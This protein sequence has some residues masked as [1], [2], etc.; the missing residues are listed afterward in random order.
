LRF[1]YPTLWSHCTPSSITA[2]TTSGPAR[3][4][5]PRQVRARTYDAVQLLRVVRRVDPGRI[6]IVGGL[7]V[8]GAATVD[9]RRQVA[10][11]ALAVGLVQE[12]VAGVVVDVRRDGS[13]E[14]RIATAATGSASAAAASA[15]RRMREGMGGVIGLLAPFAC[16]RALRRR[17]VRSLMR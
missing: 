16:G 14:R 11:I 2:I 6:A 3:G 15:R 5:A 17:R 8:A 13:R 10:V 7:E 12:Q 1:R 4:D 9:V